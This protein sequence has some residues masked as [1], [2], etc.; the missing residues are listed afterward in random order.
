MPEDEDLQI[1]ALREELMKEIEVV[2]GDLK[3]LRGR[4]TLILT[5]VGIF[6]GLASFIVAVLAFAADIL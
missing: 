4:Q 1:T 6:I 5:G 2:R 3:S